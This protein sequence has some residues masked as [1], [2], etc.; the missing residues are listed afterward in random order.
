MN[1]LKFFEN[2]TILV[3][4]GSG[5]IG[6]HL[7]EALLNSPCKSI[8]VLSNNEHELYLLQKKYGSNQKLR[9]L[10][11]DVR[12]KGRL[13]IATEGTDIVF[14]AAAVKH[15][16]LCEF[17]PFD[18]VQTNVI[19]TQN[20]IE[21][22]ISSNVEKF[23]FI[24]TDKAA[25]PLSTLGATKLLAERLTIAAMAYRRTLSRPVMYCIRFGNVLGTRGS[26]LELFYDQ[27]KSNQPITITNNKM[28][29][30]TMTPQEAVNLILSTVKIAKGGE[31]FVLK[32]RV[33]RIVDLA[34]AMFELYSNNPNHQIIEIGV[35]E[36]EKIHEDL[37]TNEELS[38]TR[39]LNDIFVIPSH[40][41]KDYDNLPLLEINYSSNLIKPM[42]VSEIKSLLQS[43]H[44]DNPY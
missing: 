5:S 14:H 20:I 43:M 7:V 39:D 44:I 8:R 36:G 16:P 33:M 22:C 32:M 42:S 24:S 26:V 3:T 18:A 13:V 19:G 1:D 23:V 35:R 40:N 6:S 29:R 38:R 30:F 4:G 2:K 31:V 11:G 15:L 12:D 37:I 21:A 28:T 41:T 17:N 9:F 34:Q 10:L 25:N 27:I